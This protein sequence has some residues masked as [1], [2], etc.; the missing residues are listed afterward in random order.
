M[1]NTL[2]TLTASLVTRKSMWLTLRAYAS[3]RSEMNFVELMQRRGYQ[4]RLILKHTTETLD[5]SVATTTKELK[6][7]HDEEGSK[8]E[9][10]VGRDAKT[11]SGG[12]FLYKNKLITKV[13]KVSLQ[14]AYY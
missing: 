5:L 14:F 13:K 4:G 3:S 9:S 10:S 1:V 6:S 7:I 2:T 11:L 8:G 12:I